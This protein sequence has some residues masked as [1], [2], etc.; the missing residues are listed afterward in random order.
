MM[1]FIDKAGLYYEGDM[2]PGDR[3]ATAEEQ[4][5]WDLV[6]SKGRLGSAL[7]EH[8]DSAARSRGYDDIQSAV[9]YA[10]ETAVAQFQAEGLALRAWRSLVWAYAYSVMASVEE[11]SR[12]VPS[13]AELI[14]ELPTLVWP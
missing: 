3:L 4:L 13:P 2:V 1:G 6:V 11:G 8:M 5:A 14:A 12:A 10:E 9:T 7:Q